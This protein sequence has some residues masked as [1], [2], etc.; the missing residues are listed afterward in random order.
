MDHSRE[1]SANQQSS[2][3]SLEERRRR[4]DLIQCYKTMNG[5]GDIEPDSRFSF[6]RARHE[7]NT[8][9]HA[10]DHII[11]DKCQRNVRKN[12]FTNR[13]AK[14]WNELPFEI[15]NARSTNSFKNL[16]DLYTQT[17]S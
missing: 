1:Q 5:Y 12:F 17:T 6:V 9:T 11:Q 13:V 2:L 8:R 4:G 7:I 15:K 14:D 3:T 10:A 16:Y